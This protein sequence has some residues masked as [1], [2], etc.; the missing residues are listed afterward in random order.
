MRGDAGYPVRFRFTK[1]GKVRW[2]GHRDVARAFE[3]ALRVARLPLAFTE[4]FSPH[5]KI[6][7]GLA[8]SVGCESDAEYLDVQLAHP[9]ALEPLAAVVSAALPDGIDVTG[10]A[11]IA[12]RAPALQEA[13]SAV[14]WRLTVASGTPGGRLDPEQVESWIASG[15][16]CREL[17]VLR[18]RKGREAVD[19]VR[20]AVR[21]IDVF[22]ASEDGGVTVGMECA[23][24]PRCPKP[25]EVVAAIAAAL[26]VPAGLTVH[27]VVR[28]AQW[29][30]RDGARLEPLDADRRPHVLE[31]RA[32]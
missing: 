7:F 14:E 17:P 4:G 29:I 12:D 18:R 23:T 27:D 21:G 30:E 26:D 9:V 13:V 11:A 1:R 15:L 19:D 3:R 8:L 6:A 5:P 2:I 10:I 24:Q 20:P 32:S 22:G 28:T 31:A 16:A 25:S